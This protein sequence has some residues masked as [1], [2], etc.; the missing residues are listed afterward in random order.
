[1]AKSINVNKKN[2]CK[3]GIEVNFLYLTKAIYENFTNIIPTGYILEACP[4]SQE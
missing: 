2:L 1:M 3:L 4:L